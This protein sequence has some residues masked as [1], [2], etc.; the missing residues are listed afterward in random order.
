MIASLTLPFDRTMVYELL[1]V[2]PGYDHV[3]KPY[4]TYKRRRWRCPDF[5]NARPSIAFLRTCQTIY[6]EATAVI[7]GGNTF[8]FSD[9]WVSDRGRTWSSDWDDYPWCGLAT[10]PLF[11]RRIRSRN[12]AKIRHIKLAFESVEFVMNVD[13]QLKPLSPPRGGACLV[14]EALKILSAAGSLRHVDLVF[15]ARGRDTIPRGLK[16]FCGPAGLLRHELAKIKGLRR[17]RVGSNMES[18]LLE[19]YLSAESRS[20]K[21]CLKALRWLKRQME[22]PLPGE[23]TDAGL[24]GAQIGQKAS[25]RS[26]GFKKPAILP[27][28][29]LDRI[30]EPIQVFQRAPKKAWKRKVPG[31]EMGEPEK[32]KP[33]GIQMPKHQRIMEQ[34][35][36]GGP[37]ETGAAKSGEKTDKTPPKTPQD[38]DREEILARITKGVTKKCLRHWRIHGKGGY[39]RIGM[40]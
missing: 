15:I 6:D 22:S 23:E 24:R 39:S 18:E 10:M 14:V 19:N 30:G 17:M 27:A 13:Q 34:L 4:Q 26:F 25:N 9:D 11:L 3:L 12:V 31:G 8:S 35:E 2:K 20:A 29:H 28:D 1:F 21:V 33:R 5:P 37:V 32:V 16:D 38:L 7:Y 40:D 36:N